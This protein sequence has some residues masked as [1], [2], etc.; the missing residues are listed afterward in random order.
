MKTL[1]TFAFCFAALLFAQVVF[2]LLFDGRNNAIT[3]GILLLFSII[4]T[5]ML[6]VTLFGVKKMF[7]DGDPLY[8]FM[9]VI[10]IYSMLASGVFCLAKQLLAARQN[11]RMQ[12]LA[13]QSR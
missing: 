3:D 9:P 12:V 1:K 7:Y 6:K 5:G 13:K 11:R 8:L 2:Y 4:P 10:I